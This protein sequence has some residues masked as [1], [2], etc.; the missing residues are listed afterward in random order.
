MS[1]QPTRT[2][3][4]D[5]LL[6]AIA[7]IALVLLP[8][9][10]RAQQAQDAGAPPPNSPPCYPFVNG[11]PVGMPKI[12]QT[13]DYWHVFWFCGDRQHTQV[14]VEGFSCR[15]SHCSESTFGQVIHQITRATAPVRTA[16][17]AWAD[18]VAVN[19]SARYWEQS[20]DG[21]MYRDRRAVSL[22]KRALW[23]EDVKWWVGQ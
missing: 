13:S 8:A 11:Y 14:S 17:T 10:A 21:A 18:H 20:P 15:Y 9:I 1:H 12:Y 6:A 16:N 4:I 7:L 19:C 22:T 3:L 5:L 2:R 23:F